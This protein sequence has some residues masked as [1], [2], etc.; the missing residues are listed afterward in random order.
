MLSMLA[1]QGWRQRG[2]AAHGTAQRHS[3][4][5]HTMLQHYTL[6]SAEMAP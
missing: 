4:A 5:E 3:T 6:H 2:I 1:R